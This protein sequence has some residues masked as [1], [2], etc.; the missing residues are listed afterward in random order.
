LSGTK[1]ISREAAIGKRIAA[2]SQGK[3]TNHT[4]HLGGV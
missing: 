4:D 3:G 2:L 1:T